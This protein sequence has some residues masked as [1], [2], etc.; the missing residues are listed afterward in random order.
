[1][2]AF[3]N[4]LQ[5]IFLELQKEDIFKKLYFNFK[6]HNTQWDND[7]RQ[8]KLNIFIRMKLTFH[9]NDSFS[10]KFSYCDE[11]VFP[12]VETITCFPTC[13]NAQEILRVSGFSNVRFSNVPCAGFGK[14][15]GRGQGVWF[16]VSRGIQ[17]DALLAAVEQDQRSILLFLLFLA[18]FASSL[19][20]EAAQHFR[21]EIC[22]GAIKYQSSS[23]IFYTGTV[24]TICLDT[25]QKCNALIHQRLEKS[26]TQTLNCKQL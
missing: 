6:I 11:M 8:N 5:I 9:L 15:I 22:I 21:V 12:S 17:V 16:C 3:Q 26:V 2:N 10:L 25:R 14:C 7:S 23:T 20:Q 13:L 19:E 24:Q 18:Q 1:M 4:Y